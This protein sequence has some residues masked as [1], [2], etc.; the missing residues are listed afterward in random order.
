MLNTST[1]TI[2]N[3]LGEVTCDSG[4]IGKTPVLH[5]IC[6]CL[7]VCL[8]GCIGSSLRHTESSLCHAASFT[9]T[10]RLSGCGMQT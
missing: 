6:R 8:F 2:I 7:F 9:V 1:N 5:F 3:S 4:N 10:H